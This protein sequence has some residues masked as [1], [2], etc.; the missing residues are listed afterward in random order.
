MIDLKFISSKVHEVQLRNNDNWEETA[1][2]L[3]EVEKGLREALKYIKDC[4]EIYE[5]YTEEEMKELF[6]GIEKNRGDRVG[7]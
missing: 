4:R 3:K 6:E 2:E 1:Q 5:S 7:T